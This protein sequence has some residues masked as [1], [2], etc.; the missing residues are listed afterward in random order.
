LRKSVFRIL[1]LVCLISGLAAYAATPASA[2]PPFDTQNF[3]PDDTHVFNTN[4]QVL[5]DKFDGT[6]Q[7]AN[8]TNVSTA[9]TTRV[10]WYACPQGFVGANNQTFGGVAGDQTRLG[11]C[12]IFIGE[13]ADPRRPV[14]GN[15]FAPTDEAYEFFWDIPGSLDGSVVD[16][17]ALACVGTGETVEG[18]NQN[19]RGD[20]ENEVRLEDAQTGNVN[21]QTSSGNIVSICT[22]DLDG[23]GVGTDLCVQGAPGAGTNEQVAARFRPFEHGSN[24]PNDGFVFRATTSLDVTDAEWLTGPGDAQTDPHQALTD[25]QNCVV[26][27]TGTNFK[28]WECRVPAASIANDAENFLDFV[29]NDPTGT[30]CTPVGFCAFESYYVVSGQRVAVQ[31]SNLTF[32]R[33]TPG[34]GQPADNTCTPADTEETN[35]VRAGGNPEDLRF[36]VVDQFGNPFN[37]QVTLVSAGPEGSGFTDCFDST[38]LFGAGTLHDHNNDGRFEHCHGDTGPDGDIMVTIDNFTDTFQDATPGDQTITACV[39]PDPMGTNAAPGT[40]SG[41]ADE[42]VVATAVKHWTA[43]PEEIELVFDQEGVND[44]TLCLTGDKF[45]ENETGDTDQLL[46]CTF[47]GAGN[48]ASTEPAGSGRLQWFIVPSGGGEL[49]AT[50]FSPNPPNET[51]GNGTNNATIEAFRPG[52]DIIEVC[53]QDDPGGNVGAGDCASVQKRVTEDTDP[54]PPPPDGPCGEIGAILGTSGNDILVGTAGDDIICGFDGDDIIRGL[55]GNDILLGQGGNDTVEGGDG[56]DTVKGGSGD[57]VL[58]GGKN[59][60]VLRGGSGADTLKGNRGNDT[61]RAGSGRDTV[62]GGRG[63]DVNNGGTGRDTCRDRFGVNVF[64]NCER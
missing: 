60:D 61:L 22:A 8:L 27:F 24:V 31:P 41:C 32:I 3:L 12:T 59:K 44:Q 11:T 37:G 2:A 10:R 36:C 7:V 23:P 33:A 51:G 6:D 17:L 50:R 47:D 38:G 64:R 52:N 63:D 55:E 34:G 9:D 18:P 40:G 4:Y 29:G 35:P 5:S 28:T 13:D 39:D 42:T 57:D 45:K 53:L 48:F 21:T 56:N 15:E 26:I 62:R 19:C 49:T 1:L 30:F 58:E 43:V 16:I 20:V 25:N 54:P 46:V 14:G